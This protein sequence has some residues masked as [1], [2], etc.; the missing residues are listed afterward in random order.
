MIFFLNG[1]GLEDR[2]SL[3]RVSDWGLKCSARKPRPQFAAQISPLIGAIETSLVAGKFTYLCERLPKHFIW[4]TSPGS[5]FCFCLPCEHETLPEGNKRATAKINFSRQ[6]Y[7]NLNSPL[8]SSLLFFLL[9]H[10]HTSRYSL[11][12]L[13]N[14]RIPTDS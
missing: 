6:C 13:K 2:R 14:W 7:H 1:Y 9:K 8:C 10:T 3:A 12:S 4:T 5:F 11:L